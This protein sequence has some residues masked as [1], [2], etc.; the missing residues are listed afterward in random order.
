MRWLLQHCRADL[1]ADHNGGDG[2]DTVDQ[3]HAGHGVT[4]LT[5]AR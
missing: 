2:E 5:A 3:V 4:S 1:P